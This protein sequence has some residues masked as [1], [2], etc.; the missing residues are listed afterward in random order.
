MG[1][2]KNRFL[3]WL[4]IINVFAFLI[5]FILFWMLWQNSTMF[6][7]KNITVQYV[8]Q[9]PLTRPPARV[10]PEPG[11][12]EPSV[13]EEDL[14]IITAVAREVK[15]NN[16]DTSKRM[17]TEQ[18]AATGTG[19]Q[20]GDLATLSDE[21]YIAS[22]DS[23]RAAQRATKQNITERQA[24]TVQATTRPQAKDATNRNR[25]NKVDLS[26]TV[27]SSYRRPSLAEQVAQVA[28]LDQAEVTGK[29]DSTEADDSARYIASLR[30]AEAERRN[31]MR[32]IIVRPGDTL[33]KIATRAYGTG[34]EYEKVF[35]A[36]PHLT[37]PD[38]IVVGEVLRVPL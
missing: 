27:R 1:G 23:I 9:P 29:A 17:K 34:F 14:S 22:Y 7:E 38:D 3:T 16:L 33:W 4:A 24:A 6:S 18:Q 35:A 15:S 31:E 21:E 26:D 37:S 10:I 25:F 32:T 20:N 36:N 8:P 12:V 30:S 19:T 13:N 5:I 28:L 2:V 11:P